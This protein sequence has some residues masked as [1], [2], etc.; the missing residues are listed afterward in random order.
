MLAV[1]VHGKETRI[2]S[3]EAEAQRKEESLKKHMQ[4]LEDTDGKESL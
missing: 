4:H 1:T 2:E 3:K